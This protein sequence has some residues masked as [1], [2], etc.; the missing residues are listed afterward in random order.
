MLLLLVSNL[1][2]A[3]SNKLVQL[4]EQT[5]Y[6]ATDRTEIDQL[7]VKYDLYSNLDIESN[8]IK[9]TL[10]N[11][12]KFMSS[13]VSCSN[14]NIENYILVMSDNE[15]TSLDREFRE[16]FSLKQDSEYYGLMISQQNNFLNHVLVCGNCDIDLEYI[17]AHGL[18]HFLA[19]QCNNLDTSEK[20]AN[21]YANLFRDSHQYN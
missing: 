18:T 21:F 8:K 19:R 16:I 14:K 2:F 11:Y 13:Y 7:T 15:L 5:N 4:K 17:I 12:F 1:L 20:T 10:S 3:S 9:N 6:V